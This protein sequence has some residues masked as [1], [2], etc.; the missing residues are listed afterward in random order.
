MPAVAQIAE[1]LLERPHAPDY[2]AAR[3]GSTTKE[4]LNILE[5]HPEIFRKVTFE[6]S[7][8]WTVIP[9][10]IIPDDEE[11]SFDEWERSS[12]PLPPLENSV[13]FRRPRSKSLAG[14]PKYSPRSPRPPAKFSVTSREIQ[15][16]SEVVS[17]RIL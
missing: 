11:Y 14:P 10:A 17:N 3:F 2:V 7:T 5:S 16:D 8:I 15:S 12:H 1:F 4:I 13:K 6:S 9:E